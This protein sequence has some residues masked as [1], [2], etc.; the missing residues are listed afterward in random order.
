MR[1]TQ[2][3]PAYIKKQ[4]ETFKG[5]FRYICKKSFIMM[6]SDIQLYEILA[7]KLGREEAKVLVEFVESK[8][9]KK[10]DEKT[11][12]FSTK[13]DIAKLETKIA[14]SKVEI[15]RWMFGIFT[16][17]ALMIVGLYFK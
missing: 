2:L 1:I 10:V 15:M 7:S 12:I 6:V 17:L 5:T 3:Y 14:E 11:T 4:N 16:V 9:E 8:A 13:E